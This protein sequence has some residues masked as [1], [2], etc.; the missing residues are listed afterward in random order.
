MRRLPPLKALR[1]FEAT[2]R[3]QSVSKAADELCLS[4]SAV[5]QQISQLEAH[6]GQALFIRQGKRV[7]ATVAA[8][9]YLKDVQA[10]FERLE[11]AGQTMRC[12]TD[13]VI[14][15]NL[16]ASLAHGWLLPKLAGFYA[17][18]PGIRIQTQIA[19]E[20]NL[21]QVDGHSDVILRRWYPGMGKTNYQ[22]RKLFDMLVCAIVAADYPRLEE[23]QTPA[24]LLQH[25]LLHLKAISQGWNYFFELAGVEHA[26]LL[27]GEF[28]AEFF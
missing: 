4:H 14:T 27:P 15:V 19:D 10:C 11:Q 13:G 28:Y 8:L 7:Q 18:H 24:D 22:V 16:S 2:A 12:H 17:M 9:Q 21:E 3:L 26:Q 25:R 6:F 20:Q 1:G 23:I 5:S